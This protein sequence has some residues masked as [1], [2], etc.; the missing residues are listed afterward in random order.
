MLRPLVASIFLIRT[1]IQNLTFQ[2]IFGF[3]K[4]IHIHEIVLLF[5]DTKLFLKERVRKNYNF[6]SSFL[7]F[8]FYQAIFLALLIA[9]LEELSIPIRDKRFFSFNF[10]LMDIILIF[11]LAVGML[12][13]WRLVGKKFEYPKLI[14]SN[15]YFYSVNFVFSVIFMIAYFYHLSHGKHFSS[16]LVIFLM[17]CGFLWWIKRFWW[18]LASLKK[19]TTKQKWISLML[20]FLVIF[21]PIDWI[22]R[23][24]SHILGSTS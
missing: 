5:S 9:F 10:V 6:K 3:F 20:F 21:Y 19:C 24:L 11:V 18:A 17:I 15:L 22:G 16:G 7:F 1:Q 8:L 12:I 14:V 23:A 2:N 4:Y 13:A